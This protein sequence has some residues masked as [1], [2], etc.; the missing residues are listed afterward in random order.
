MV[1]RRESCGCWRGDG[2]YPYFYG[3]Q[4]RRAS[5]CRRV[6]GS[7]TETEVGPT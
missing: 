1:A 6:Y 7:P 3:C 5:C 4:Y 2:A